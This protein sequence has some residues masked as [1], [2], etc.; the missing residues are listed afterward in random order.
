LNSKKVL[1]AYIFTLKRDQKRLCLV[2]GKRIEI[3]ETACF[4]YSFA[5]VILRSKTA[6]ALIWFLSSIDSDLSHSL[7]KTE[8][9]QLPA[10]NN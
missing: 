8:L 7:S 5:V 2:V 1:D 9:I 6:D 3:T 10:A 4:A